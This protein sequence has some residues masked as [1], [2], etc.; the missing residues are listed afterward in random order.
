[1][2]RPVTRT[3]LKDAIQL[4]YGLPTFGASTP[5]T[6]TEVETMIN[7]S[8]Q[9]YF[10]LLQEYEAEEWYTFED[11]ISTTAGQAY[12]DL[13]TGLSARFL[14]V[15]AVH[16]LRGTDD[17]VTLRRA[18]KDDW[19][20]RSF[21]AR[22]W[23]EA[24]PE[25]LLVRDRLYFMPPPSAVYSVRLWYSGAPTDF[26]NDAAT[27]DGGPGWEEF[28]VA[29]VCVKIAEGEEEDAQRFYVKRQAAEQYIRAQCGREKS[30]PVFVRR[31]ADQRPS[32]SDVDSDL[33]EPW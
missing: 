12:V 29:D 19:A 11:L 15:R 1:M 31:V 14:N 33:Y 10:G 3:M 21:A 2:G 16:W 24:R 26:A 30:D 17:I 27:M 18:Q 13:S 4:A 23:D 20:R 32:P 28:V 7:A 22:S 6:T 9:K 5:V 25:Y 8:V